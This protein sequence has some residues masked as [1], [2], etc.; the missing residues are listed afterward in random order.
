[1]SDSAVLTFTDLDEYHASIRGAQVDGVITSRGSFRVKWTG[2]Q[3][4]RLSMQRSEET[5]PRI[6][7]NAIDRKVYGIVLATNPR[8][9]SAY[10]R[11]LELSPADIIVYGVASVGH[12]RIPAAFQ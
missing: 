7:S 1:M 9:P 2:I 6:A 12:N 11:G 5:L 4:D 10:I 8:Q 3:L